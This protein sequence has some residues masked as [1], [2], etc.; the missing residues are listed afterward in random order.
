MHDAF[1]LFRVYE[2]PQRDRADKI[3]IYTNSQSAVKARDLRSND[4]RALSIKRAYEQR[5]PTGYFITKRG[6]TTPADRNSN[7][8]VDLSSFAK[9]SWHGRRCARISYGETKIFNKYFE[10]LFKNRDYPPEDVLAL[11]EWMN[12]VRNTWAVRHQ[13]FWAN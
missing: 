5:Y 8:V 3:S 6:E 12:D 10:T 13:D 9:T 7:H 11:N 1:I 4:K 2:I